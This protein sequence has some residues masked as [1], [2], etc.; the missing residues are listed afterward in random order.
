MEKFDLFKKLSEANPSNVAIEHDGIKYTYKE[1]HQKVELLANRLKA[2]GVTNGSLVGVFLDRSVYT[3]VSILSIWK[4]GGV[5]V[6]LNKL[7][8]EKHNRNI[9]DDSGIEFLL[10]NKE[11]PYHLNNGLISIINIGIDKEEE[12]E[13]QLFTNS[14][15]KEVIGE[16]PAYIIHTSGTTGKPKGI[17]V[18]HN[19]ISNY[20]EWC[21]EYFQPNEL[22]R[23]LFSGAVS[24]DISLMEMLATLYHHGTLVI[25]ES[26][27]DVI[28]TDEHSPTSMFVT[29]SG[30]GEL[31]LQDRVPSSLQTL[32][33]GGEI[34]P[35]NMAARIIDKGI[36]LIN[37]Y[38]PSETTILATSH[39]VTSDSLKEKSIPIG[40]PI[41]NTSIKIFNQ[42]NELCQNEE[43]GELVIYGKS[44]SLGYI[45][46]ES[47]NNPF[48][49]DK[50]TGQPFYRSGDLGFY[51]KNGLIEICGRKDTQVKLRGFRID[52]HGLE[53]ILEKQEAV[54]KCCFL[55]DK[56]EKVDVLHAFIQIKHNINVN[57]EEILKTYKDEVPGYCVP[58]QIHIVDSFPLNHNGKLDT[59]YL[60]SK[61]RQTLSEEHIEKDLDE[62][63]LNDFI[64]LFLR[65]ELNNPTVKEDDN[66]YYVG[67]NSLLGMRLSMEIQK[68]FGCFI[69]STD[70][71]ELKTPK[72]VAAEY[73]QNRWNKTIEKIGSDIKY[74]E[75]QLCSSNQNRLLYL[76]QKLNSNDSFFNEYYIFEIKGSFLLEK[77][78]EALR[79][80]IR[81]HIPLNI[82]Y[83]IVN[84]DLYQEY[85][86]ND[87]FEINVEELT[88]PLALDTR[89][90]SEINK[91]F[92]LLEERSIRCTVFKQQATYTCIINIHHIAFDG[93]SED[94]FFSELNVAYQS[95]LLN[96]PP[97][98]EPLPTSFYNYCDSE[99]NWINTPEYQ[100]SL[101]Y[102]KK[103]L[104]IAPHVHSIPLDFRREK[105]S[106]F[107]GLRYSSKLS[108]ESVSRLNAICQENNTTLFSG[109][110]SILCLAIEKYSF[111]KEICIGTPVA[112]RNTAE[113]S[114]L[115]GFFVNTVP[116]FVDL[117][118]TKT[119]QDVLEKCSNIV[120]GALKH[121]R[122]PLT[123][124]IDALDVDRDTSYSPLL[125]ILLVYEDEKEELLEIPGCTIVR[126]DYYNN[127]TQFDLTFIIRQ[128]KNEVELVIEYDDSIFDESTITALSSLYTLILDY[129]SLSPAEPA[130]D[131]PLLKSVKLPE[132]E[133]TQ[134]NNLQFSTVTEWFEEIAARQ[135]NAI[136]LSKGN[137]Y[138]TYREL[139]EKANK[140]SHYLSKIGIKRGMVVCVLFDRSV[141]AIISI[142]A[143]MK[144][145]AAYLPLENNVPKKR[146]EYIINTTKLEFILTDGNLEE[147]NEKF[148]T[149]NLNA[150]FIEEEINKC[151]STNL[152]KVHQ[153]DLAYVL[154]TSGTTGQPKGAKISH[155][156]IVSHLQSAHHQYKMNSL[157]VTLQYSSLNF[158][159]ASSDILCSL[160]CGGRL[161]LIDK[162]ILY[163]SKRLSDEIEKEEITH[164]NIASSSL[165]TIEIRKNY[166]LK[167][168]NIGGEVC[169]EDLIEKWK[170]NC[171]IYI[172]YGPTECA[173]CSSSI[174]IQDRK[175]KNSIGKPIGENVY[176][177][178]DSYGNI[179]PNGVPGYLYIAGPQVMDGY[180][181]SR[182]GGIS[183]L[184]YGS[185]SIKAYNSNDIV[186]KMPSGEYQFLGRK[187]GLVKIN[188]HRISLSEISNAAGKKEYIRNATVMV[189][190]LGNLSSI[191]VLFVQMETN[192][193]EK[194]Q[195]H[196][197][198]NDLADEL[199]TYMIPSR[200]IPINEMPI[201]DNG[202][203]DFNKL[204][205][206]LES[207]SEH[208]EPMF[209]E[210]F[211]ELESGVLDLW[212]E[213]LGEG[214]PKEIDRSFFSVGGNSLLYIKLLN[215]I[216]V[217]YG[218]DF[219]LEE[220]GH[221]QTV[222]EMAKE[223]EHK[224]QLIPSDFNI[225]DESFVEEW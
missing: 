47:N 119:F 135:P 216:R 209:V 57:K 205:S 214:I 117:N 212:I 147:I 108:L 19:N 53:A 1:L 51:N 6:P 215:N 173:V 120:I 44:V 113:F 10:V 122:M 149:I 199:P 176:L 190:N 180:V 211:T 193:D 201:T 75:M 67:C 17:M 93:I 202:K 49:Y 25:V 14:I 95:L 213:L 155:Q 126:K 161:H 54:E 188:G 43:I 153:T 23:C 182:N 116:L 171:E 36:R 166:S 152:Q 82:K 69:P 220:M 5:Y 80:V 58:N 221:L 150:A 85:I 148:Q 110:Y 141:N 70:L 104:D 143:V 210:S 177:V 63:N 167:T 164:I 68:R 78:E 100:T 128:K 163:S 114:N 156:A 121:Q 191:I 140:L 84:G 224:K 162:E 184:T 186:R 88:D 179:V 146:L 103:A 48:G 111:E 39:I 130:F 138:L 181:D 157:T 9:I 125:Q 172:S 194:E 22:N 87:N 168:I 90:I 41:S 7:L 174:S 124:I 91:G 175:E 65:N 109:L 4:A 55:I 96:R 187:D 13:Q 189:H 170:G 35:K 59:G 151:P 15:S 178:C 16:Q 60:L 64:V 27:L 225:K 89:I 218:R 206:I 20:L 74:D 123:D 76:N 142:L 204:K 154:F 77:L 79:I 137:V 208:I 102:W 207:S 158:D 42:E 185:N 24:F 192:V 134:Q 81:R 38:G 105:I 52:L 37:A 32:I 92:N 30:F 115:I 200:I 198:K 223:I 73:N 203:M 197:L 45:N 71:L 139:N 3:I 61:M 222:R 62:N 160:T 129:F 34:L 217:T 31:L 11:V 56:N 118:Q 66:F 26:V 33:L 29:P 94:I 132:L 195:I 112:N 106:K 145:G 136:A 83:S 40:T 72:N 127:K 21:Y 46:A 101:E 50:T 183:Y 219:T 8:P 144:I 18:S 107:S 99:K 131:V 2:N 169:P 28:N 133:V 97:T 165:S 12:V 196:I 86:E 159:V 98:L